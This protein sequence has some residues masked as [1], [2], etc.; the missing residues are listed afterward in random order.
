MINVPCF[1]HNDVSRTFMNHTFSDN[2]DINRVDNH[3]GSGNCLYRS[4]F[5]ILRSNVLSTSPSQY[6]CQ[7]KW[8]NITQPEVKIYLMMDYF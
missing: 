6:I 8:K 5:A 2:S 7:D 1:H 4:T 3:V